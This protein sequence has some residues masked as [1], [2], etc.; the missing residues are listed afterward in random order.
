MPQ[1]DPSVFSPQIIWLLISFF[2]LYLI[3]VKT[4]LPKVGRVL[5]ERQNRITDDLEHAERLK[6]NSVDIEEQ[7]EKSLAE[8]KLAAT[9]SIREAKDVLQIELDDDQAET[10]SYISKKL[11]TAEGKIT[12]AKAEAMTELEDIAVDAA[13]SIV[14]KLTGFDIPEPD[15]RLH[16]RSEIKAVTGKGP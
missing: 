2:V 1:L 12:S 13:R 4:G 8:A 11:A 14:S 15:A 7:Y 3:M 6:A 10:D 9:N 16:V 5:E